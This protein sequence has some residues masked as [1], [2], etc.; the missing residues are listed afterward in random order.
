M[1]SLA[2][3]QSQL[4]SLDTKEALRTMVPSLLGLITGGVL[5]L[6]CLPI[7]LF[8]VALLLVETTDLSH[9]QAFFITL[10]VGLVVGV[11]SCYWAYF[12]LR[13]SFQP[14]QRSQAEWRSNVVWFKN[15][16]KRV[17]RRL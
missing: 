1:V 8:S 14:F 17:S 4:L 12:A 15:V 9:A 13:N 11:G 16:L 7:T 10:L 2:E 6:S 5:I 3:L